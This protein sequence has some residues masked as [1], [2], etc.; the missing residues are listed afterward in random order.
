MW[1]CKKVFTSKFSY[2]LLWNPTHKSDKTETGIAN[3]WG[4]TNSKPS[5]PI[6][7]MGQSEIVI[8]SQI[9]FITLFSAGAQ[10]CCAFYQPRQSICT[11]AVPKPFS[12]AKPACFDFSFI[13]LYCAA[14]DAL[15]GFPVDGAGPH[16]PIWQGSNSLVVKSHGHISW[17]QI[18]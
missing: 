8:S 11:Y 6:I 1:P 16:K 17:L 4:T 10:H 18:W 13:Q 2:I 9:I 3:T 15:S 14:Q 5:G 7:M 12:W